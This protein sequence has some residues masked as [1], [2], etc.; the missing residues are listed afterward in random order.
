M[1][2]QEFF[3]F[4]HTK[5][6]LIKKLY[7]NDCTGSNRA[8]IEWKMLKKLMIVCTRN[9]LYRAENFLESTNLIHTIIWDLRVIRF[10]KVRI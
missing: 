4:F 6:L 3:V 9:M 8:R 1:K 2:I 5:Q 10:L 7:L